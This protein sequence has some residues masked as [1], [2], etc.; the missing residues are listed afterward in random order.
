MNKQENHRFPEAL[1]HEPDAEELE[2]VWT[3]LEVAHDAAPVS[4]ERTDAAWSALSASLGLEGGGTS[5]SSTTP[6]T[7]GQSRG[8]A[9]PSAPPA[10]TPWLRVAAAVAVLIGGLAVWQQIPVTHEAPVG[11]RM[12]VTLPDG[13]SVELNAGSTLSLRRGFALVPGVPQGSRVVR[14][15]GEAFFDVTSGER[16]FQVVAGSARITVLGTRFNVRA[17]SGLGVP[18]VVRVDVEEGRVRVAGDD[19]E[20]ELGA[21]ESVRVE[22]GAGELT[23]SRVPADRIAPWRNGGLTVSDETLAAVVREVGLRFGTNVALAPDVDGSVRVT[24]FYPLLTGIETVLRD[25]ATQQNLRVRQT[26]LG[27]ELF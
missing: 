7:V 14:L 10:R 13:S 5:T 15:D 26:S 18:P 24:A 19:A 9:L 12:A 27:W 23:P 11:Q 8:G 4:S 20:T 16:P 3:A 6:G 21:G 2:A 17:R 25:L 22:A 1:S